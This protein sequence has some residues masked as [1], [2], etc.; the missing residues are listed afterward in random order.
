MRIHSPETIEKIRSKIRAGYISGR[1][2]HNKG[3]SKLTYAPLAV[4]SKKMMG[5][6][7]PAGK[8]GP[9]NPMW[10]KSAP[11]LKQLAA[12][13]IGLHDRSPECRKK[14]S[15]RAK[16]SWLKTRKTRIE[17]MRKVWCK[18][19]GMTYLETKFK[20]LC[21]KFNLPFKY[22]GNGQLW[23]TSCGIHINPDFVDTLGLKLVVEV[24]ARCWKQSTYEITRKTA[25]CSAGYDSLFL[26]DEIMDET[27]WE[28]M[29]K[30]KVASFIKSFI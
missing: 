18:H 3:R 21:E 8:F 19:R 28:S 26:S 1:V 25:L 13:R 12:A 5:N 24:Y 29:C 14:M 11:H 4:V 15:I 22:V 17:A 2:P 7:N 27:N 16:A 23:I 30:D 9:L 6:K 10:G 20:S